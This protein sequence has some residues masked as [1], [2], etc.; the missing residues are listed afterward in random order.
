MENK[1]VVFTKPWEVEFQ[2]VEENIKIEKATD[3]IVKTN[4]SLI[5][6]GTE[7]ACLSGGEEWF[8]LPNTPGYIAV[9]TVEETGS[10]VDHVKKGDMVFT[11]APH[12][13]YNKIDTTD[14]Y[15]GMCKK[16]PEGLSPQIAPF[17]RMANIAITSVRNS[18][19]ELGDYVAV[20]GMGLVGNFA[21]Q[22]AQLQG[23]KV[24]GIDIDNDRLELAKKCGIDLVVNSAKDGWKESIQ[25]ITNGEGVSTLID[26]TGLSA[27]ITNSLDI[28]SLYGEVL[29][30]G[31]PRA[32]YETN[33]TDI[34]NKVHLPNFANLKGAL[35]W[36]FPTFKNEFVKHSLERNS[37]IIMN[38]IN[39][40]KLNVAPL[41]THTLSPEKSPE[42]YKGLKD[43]KDKF[44][45]VVF[46]W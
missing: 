36:R 5:S 2:S 12:A 13:L 43:K 38:L 34:Y 16:L 39:E 23:A 42:A 7:L 28:V 41:L 18:N 11:Y 22:L 26:A 8:P 15:G 45:G 40:E 21:A 3:V 25:A 29:L 10:D 27:V 19:I 35:E 17:T 9:G 20:T 33:V 31:S 32:P 30:L 4:Y 6:A 24:I 14:R 37:E 1:K 46:Q 44:I